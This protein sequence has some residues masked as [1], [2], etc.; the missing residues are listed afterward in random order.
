MIYFLRKLLGQQGG[1]Y[2]RKEAMER[3]ED[4]L[5]SCKD[6][7]NEEL[8]AREGDTLEIYF[9]GILLYEIKILMLAVKSY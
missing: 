1:K 7:W 2:A 8:T 6:G 9:G 5:E 3:V 4:Q